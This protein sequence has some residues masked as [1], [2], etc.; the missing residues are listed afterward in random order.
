MTRIVRPTAADMARVSEHR[1]AQFRAHAIPGEALAI[2]PGGSGLIA[3]VLRGAQPSPQAFGFF[4][5][6][7]GP[8]AFDPEA[9]DDGIAIL[10]VS[11]P[12]EHH[13]GWCCHSYE[14][15]ARE[16]ECALDHPEVKALA[17]KI[18]SPGGVAAGMG[19]THR[20]LRRLQ[21]EYRKPIYA[22]AD[23]M[24]CSAA[25]HLA[26]ACAE[27]WT[28]PEGH[29][30]SI[31]VIL[32][33]VDESAALDKA[34]VAVRYIVTGKRKADLHPGA[35]V[36]DEVIAVAQAKVDKL[37]RHFFRAVGRS[38]GDRGLNAEAAKQLQAGVFIGNDAVRVGLADGIA[39]WD[40]FLSLVRDTIKP[41]ARAKDPAAVAMGSRGGRA[42]AEKMTPEERS[43]SARNAINARWSNAHTKRLVPSKALTA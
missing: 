31:G 4:Y 40:R 20:A 3:S 24:A 17:L 18:D 28:T 8:L 14:A 6:V 41:Q 5:D 37:G 10:C 1:R 35:P 36:T 29:L 27:I 19:E 38:R 9:I 11:G 15:I 23:E 22:F 7:P 13:E 25:Y 34:G 30:G 2:D 33:A 32:C 42:R 43:K 21:R 16:V 26:S 12:I 39:S